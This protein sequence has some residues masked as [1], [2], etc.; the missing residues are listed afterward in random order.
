MISSFTPRLLTSVINASPSTEL[1]PRSFII[2]SIRNNYGKPDPNDYETF[3]EMVGMN[4][5]YWQFRADR[6]EKI[7]STNNFVG[8][9]YSVTRASEN[10]EMWFKAFT[11][12]G[13]VDFFFS[14]KPIEAMQSRDSLQNQQ[15]TKQQF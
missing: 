1:K 14:D 12:G 9:W 11:E 7:H 5:D 13:G 8:L 10:E 6:V 2:Q 4:I 15:L 3:D